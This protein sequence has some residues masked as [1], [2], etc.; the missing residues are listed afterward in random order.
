MNNEG[1]RRAPQ[2]T[3]K[4]NKNKFVR[5]VVAGALSLLLGHQTLNPD[6]VDAIG[7]PPKDRVDLEQ[8]L[9]EKAATVEVGGE[10]YRTVSMEDIE[11]PLKP[12]RLAK[13]QIFVIRLQPEEN[14]IAVRNLATGVV[15][16]ISIRANHLTK[17]GK[18]VEEY[19][20]LSSAESIGIPVAVTE[21]SLVTMAGRSSLEKGDKEIRV[22]GKDPRPDDG[23]DA[24]SIEISNFPAGAT[25][26]MIDSSDS[27]INKQ[28]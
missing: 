9:D 14:S 18:V 21:E 27:S 25:D 26:S 16:D 1:E 6:Q 5:S 17:A 11:D 12:L 3:P 8:V 22:Y 19:Q 10:T 20:I 15:T 4:A 2:E 28:D 7:S 24:D 23:S 13:D